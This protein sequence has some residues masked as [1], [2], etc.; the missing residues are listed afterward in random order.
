IFHNNGGR[1]VNQ[2]VTGRNRGKVA[3]ATYLGEKDPAPQATDEV[4][5]LAGWMTDPKNPFFARATVNRLW[6]YYFG[7]GVIQPVDDMRATTPESVPGLLD[8]LAE[9]LVKTKYDIKQVT[10]LILNS[11]TYQFSSVPNESNR[12]DDR[13]FSHYQPKAMPAQVLLDMIDQAAG[14]AE[15]FDSW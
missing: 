6:S 14:V 9:E 7:R 1:V 4:D 5:A 10:K 2:S 11:K 8:A 12:L 3:P 15:Q 13:F